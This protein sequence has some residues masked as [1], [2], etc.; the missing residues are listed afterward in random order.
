MLGQTTAMS[1]GV[2]NLLGGNKKWVAD[3]NKADPTFFKRN[4]IGQKPKCA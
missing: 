4:A 1:V 3:M 2:D